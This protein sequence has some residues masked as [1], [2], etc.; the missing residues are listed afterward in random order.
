MVQLGN[1]GYRPKFG[2]VE[3]VP[4]PIVV[5]EALSGRGVQVKEMSFGSYL[6]LALLLLALHYFVKTRI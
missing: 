6:G 5:M 4:N 3:Q 1:T 2:P